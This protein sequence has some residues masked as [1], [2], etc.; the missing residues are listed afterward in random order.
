[1]KY[2][3]GI[4]PDL[5]DCGFGFYNLESKN[6]YDY[7]IISVSKKYKGKDAV[8]AMADKLLWFFDQYIWSYISLVDECE[9]LIIEGQQI[10]TGKGRARPNDL[11]KL[12]HVTGA[13]LG[14]AT[15]ALGPSLVRIPTPREW[16]G[17]VPKPIHQERTCR[18]LGWPCKRTQG[19]TYP[20]GSRGAHFK[21]GE[22]KQVMDGIGLALWGAKTL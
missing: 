18:A 4:D 19:Y 10:Y 12:A 3:F 11:L 13:I 5:H 2:V 6:I 9:L 16:K 1:M 17:N 21:P 20:T 14:A 22:W 8:L 7:G 15:P